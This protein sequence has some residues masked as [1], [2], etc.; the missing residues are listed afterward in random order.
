M[1]LQ[2]KRVNP[3]THATPSGSP[4]G[5]VCGVLGAATAHGRAGLLRVNT[6]HHTRTVHPPVG[7]WRKEY[8]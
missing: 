4:P 2:P 8:S 7:H 3:E 1:G 5:R 6:P